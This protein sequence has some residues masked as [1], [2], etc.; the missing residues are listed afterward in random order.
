MTTIAAIATPNAPGGIAVIRIS[1]ER[2]FEVAEKIFVPA[3]DKKVA[4]M[5]GYTCAYGEAFDGEERLD[6][7]ILTV[8]RAPHSFT[9]EDT[10]EISCHGGIYV[11]RRILRAALANGAVMAQ[12]G[13][14]TKRAFL[15]GKIDLT[16]AESVMDIISAKG[17]RELKMAENIREG[18]AYKAVRKISDRLMNMLGSLAA[19]TDYPDEDIPEVEPETMRTELENIRAELESLIRNYDSGRILREGVSTVIVG[20]PNVGKSTLFNALSGCERSI[21]TDIAGTTRDAVEETVKLGDV[22]LRL[23]D[24][25]GIRETSDKIEE[26]GV[27]IAQK[28]IESAELVIAVFDGS[29]KMGDDDVNIINKIN[30]NNSVAVVNKND[31]STVIDITELEKHFKHIVY[32][33]AKE[34][35]GMD[36]LCACI[37]DI[38]RLNEPFFN[39]VTVA[40]ERQK[41]CVDVCLKNVEKAVEAIECGEMLDAVNVLI[42]YAEQSLL[43]LIGEKITDAVVDEVFSRFCVGK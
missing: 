21:V 43:E 34:N 8:F 1:G 38:F 16:Q 40:N 35:S 39:D 19:W 24:T 25:A 6:D 37:E 17:E 5:R 7:C 13:E 20:R 4:D 12:A 30:F 36:E 22:T 11:T 3:G 2:A 29:E 31:L 9:G 41:K 27:N 26:I 10:A 33:S 32:L 18:A 23:M 14:F 15:N 28:A 42:D